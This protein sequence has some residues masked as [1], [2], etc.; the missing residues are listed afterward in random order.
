MQV[1]WDKGTATVSDVVE[2]VSK[3]TKGDPPAY[4]TI[5]TTLRI[6]ERKGFVRHTKESR[7]FIYHPVVHRD[8]ATETAIAHLLRRFFDNSAEQLVLKLLERKQID[9]ET[10]RRLR[11]QIEEKKS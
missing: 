8:K 7:A 11:K 6:L 2:A 9:A 3:T 1:L 4:S 10:I 5:L